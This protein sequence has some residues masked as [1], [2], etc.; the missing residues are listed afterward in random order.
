MISSAHTIAVAAWNPAVG[1][2][3]RRLATPAAQAAAGTGPHGH[4]PPATGHT[5]TEVRAG[6]L[7]ACPGSNSTPCRRTRRIGTSQ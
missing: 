7:P 2:P 4:L 1:R 5:D 6:V 3:G